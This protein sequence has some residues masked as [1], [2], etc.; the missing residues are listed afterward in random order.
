MR[1]QSNVS[2]GQ[3]GYKVVQSG[4]AGAATVAS[5]LV[6]GSAE[7]TAV[8]TEALDADEL[9]LDFECIQK[10]STDG[11]TT[12]PTT[13]NAPEQQKLLS[14]FSMTASCVVPLDDHSDWHMISD[15][16]DISLSQLFASHAEELSAL[17]AMSTSQSLS[18]AQDMM[19]TSWFPVSSMKTSATATATATAAATTA[20]ATAAAATST[21]ES[22][23]DTTSFTTEQ[24]PHEQVDTGDATATSVAI[25]PADEG[26]FL[27]TE[28]AANS[29]DDSVPE[30]VSPS[31]S[32][33]DAT[34]CSSASIDSSAPAQTCASLATASLSER[35]IESAL[36]ALT[37]ALQVFPLLPTP[38]VELIIEAPA[39]DEIVFDSVTLPQNTACSSC[40]ISNSTEALHEP[41]PFLEMPSAK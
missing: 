11:S 14:S 30:Q 1:L 26:W 15:D 28:S 4:A 39:G 32:T 37:G 16:E 20:A 36:V 38:G 8:A 41:L 25:E 18:N 31:T 9:A 23:T 12:A 6:G 24:T 7:Q 13:R 34:P 22:S 10:L 33:T 2:G 27:V 5:Y 19:F 40:N 3:L 29:I 17:Q 21:C 35:D